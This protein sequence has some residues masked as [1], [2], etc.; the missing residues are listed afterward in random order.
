VRLVLQRVR[1]ASVT[2]DGAVVAAIGPGVLALVGFGREDGPDFV[3][4]PLCRKLLDKVLDLR[5]FPD[6]AGKLNRSLLE[7]GGELLLVSQFTLFA[8]C[9]KGR[10]P[11]FTDAAEPDVARGLFE[12]FCRLA[13][14]AL[15]GRVSAG[16][17]GADMDV[18]L[19]NWGPVTILL[20]SV[21]F[22]GAT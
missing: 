4:S 16:V 7:A 12:A 5:I 22:S 6:E 2:V 21:D 11:S 9:R 17:F 14:Q 1:E 18:R 19:C 20:D 15:P 8:S 3:S 10:R 13:E